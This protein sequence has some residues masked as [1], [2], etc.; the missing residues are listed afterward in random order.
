MIIRRTFRGLPPVRRGH[1]SSDCPTQVLSCD[2][3]SRLATRPVCNR[4]FLLP[5]VTAGR[6]RCAAH[7]I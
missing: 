6:F 5:C 3:G 4:E 2:S 7:L 1:S